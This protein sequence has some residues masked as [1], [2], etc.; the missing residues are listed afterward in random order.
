MA[1]TRK[2]TATTKWN[3]G[4]VAPEDMTTSQRIAHEVVDA[5]RDLVPSVER[6]MNAGLSEADQDKAM[7]LFQ[8]SLT[9][10]GDPHR[11]PRVAIESSRSTPAG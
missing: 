11:D 8:A 4:S 9:Q 6:I 3:D 1:T 7:T 2:K 5:R 10:T